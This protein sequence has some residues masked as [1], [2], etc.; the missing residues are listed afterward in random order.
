MARS[1]VTK[2]REVLLF[3]DP[4]EVTD[5]VDALDDVMRSNR[6]LTIDVF[7]R[8]LEALKGKVPDVLAASTIA[9]TCRE[10]LK[11]VSVKD[12]DV[13]ALVR[14]LQI[15]VPDLV[16]IDGDKI[17][18]N[19]SAKRVA[20]AVEAQLENLHK[21]FDASGDVLASGPKPA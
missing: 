11:V 8:A 19:A 14:G 6:G 16:G 3:H 17:A 5:W 18:V 9:F 13:I 1:P 12:A 20:A 21:D 10:Q 7:L 4:K 2:F 15:I